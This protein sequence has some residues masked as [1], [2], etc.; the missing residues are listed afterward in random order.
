MN[1]SNDDKYT[2]ICSS[3]TIQSEEQG[4]FSEFYES[5]RDTCGDDWILSDFKN[6]DN[7][8]KKIHAL[9]ND[10][11]VCDIILGTLEHVKPVF[12][13]KNAKIS[14]QR[15]A[16]GDACLKNGDLNT[17]LLMYSQAVM[18][19]PKYGDYIYFHTIYAYNIGY[20]YIFFAL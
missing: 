19:A 14:I 11:S 10:P 18:R 16:Q 20:S 8:R 6:L 15:R 2:N 4:F 12:K 3:I 17:A 1:Q 13:E 5:A 7:D 9:Y